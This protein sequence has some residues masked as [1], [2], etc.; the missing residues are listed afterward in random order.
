MR[1][2]EIE[3]K[4]KE[5]QKKQAIYERAMAVA[6]I[7]WSTAQAIMAAWTNPWTAPGMIPLIIAAGAVQAAS[8]LAT[9]IPEYAKGTKDHPGGLAIVGDGGRS[10]MILSNGVL[11]KT[12]ATD[13]LIDLP[14]HSVVYPDFNKAISA[15]MPPIPRMP[16]KEEKVISFESLEKLMKENNSQLK[17]SIGMAAKDTKTHK[18]LGLYNFNKTVLR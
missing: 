14:A 2:E 12:P 1:E 11:F 13:T 17:K 15:F 8:V 5:L 16:E 4:R 9:P 18:Y 10:E 7:G 6:Q 3:A